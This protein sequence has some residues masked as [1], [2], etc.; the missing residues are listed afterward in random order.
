MR[1][2]GFGSTFPKSLKN[3]YV[4]SHFFSSSTG[5]PSPNRPE[6]SAKKGEIA[7]EKKM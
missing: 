5:Q 6:A 3:A 7:D 4:I 2:G 1:L